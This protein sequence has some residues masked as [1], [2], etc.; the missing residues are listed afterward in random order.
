MILMGINW[1]KHSAI[2]RLESG[3]YNPSVRLLEKVAKALGLK[4][5]V[6]FSKQA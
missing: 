3:D 6:S 2:S 5:I 1:T 4:L